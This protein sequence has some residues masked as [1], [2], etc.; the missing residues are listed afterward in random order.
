MMGGVLRPE[1]KRCKKERISD[2]NEFELKFKRKKI[3]NKKESRISS[4]SLLLT[5]AETMRLSMQQL[6]ETEGSL[7]TKVLI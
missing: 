6:K 2:D 4:F 7:G 1:A 5:E 3:D